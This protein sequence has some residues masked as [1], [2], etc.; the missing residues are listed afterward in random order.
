MTYL[1]SD[2]VIIEP[3]A[4][5]KHDTSL[6][7]PLRDFTF[8]QDG[9]GTFEHVTN[10]QVAG[11]RA[12]GSWPRS[13]SS[14]PAPRCAAQDSE[15]GLDPELVAVGADEGDYFLCW[16]A[17]SAPKKAAMREQAA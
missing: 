5:Q 14:G 9:A 10:R 12:V 11:T 7:R 2:L 17:S 8:R 3:A 1:S 13:R 15:D 4:K 6:S 16:R